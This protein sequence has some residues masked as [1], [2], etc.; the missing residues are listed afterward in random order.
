MIKNYIKIA[1]RNLLRNKVQTFINVAG[2]SLGMAV[3]MLIGFW[4][5]DELSFN[6]YFRNYDRIVQ[7]MQHQ[8][9]NGDVGTQAAI[10]MPLAPK[11]LQDYKADFKYMVMSSWTDEH[12]ITSGDKKLTQLGNYMQ[13]DAP[14][15][16]SLKM[17][18]GSRSGLTDQSSILLSATLAKSLFGDADP[19]NKAVRIDNRFNVKVTGVYEDMPLNTTFNDVAFISTWDLY[20]TTEPYLKKMQSNWDN[21]SWQLFAQINPGVDVSD[22]SSKIRNVKLTVYKTQGNKMALSF[23]PILFLQPMSKWHLYAEFKNGV[24]T[25]GAI[26]F[27]WMFGIIGVFVLVLACI[28]F[29]NLSTARSE[30]RAKEVG[31]RK[32]LGSDR[33]Q[34]ISQFYIESVLIAVF[35]F[36]ISLLL[37]QLAMPW[38]NNVAGKQMQVLWA[39]PFFWLM[40]ICFSLLTGV[41]AGS[42]PALYLSSF[43]P[44]KVLKGT[45]KAGRFAALPRKVLVVLQFAV[46]VML[47]IGTIVVF[48]QVEYTKDRPVGY[49]RFGLIQV[50]MKNDDIHK[51]F[52]ALRND[53]IQSGAVAEIAESGSPVTDIYSYTSDI[54]WQ[55]KDPA[56]QTNFATIPVTP[57]FG[58]T[59]GWNIIKG[60]DY[61]RKYLTD[62]SAV[63]L[64]EAAVKFM[65]FK[66]P[67]GQ[68]L[69]QGNSTYKVIGVIKDMVMTSPY[70][71]VNPT[72]FFQLSYTGSVVNIRINPK[73]GIHNAMARIITIFKQYDPDSPFNYNFSDSEYAMKF[74]DEERVGTLAGFFTVL[75][76]FISCLGLFGMAL[77][78]AEQRTKEIGVR[79]VLGASVLNLWGLMSKDFVALVSISILIATPIAYYFMQG[80]VK[81]YK[82]HEEL[83]WWIFVATAAGAIIITLLTVSYQSIKAALTNPVK[84]LRSE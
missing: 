43:M 33:K 58:K 79:K 47:I 49:S 30:K 36:L 82:Y 18:K 1:W 59:V 64:N 35:S 63:I 6:K 51:H 8:T 4:I 45:F 17:I 68:M 40:G 80:W 84:S 65:G 83:S 72:I 71:P 16:L 77:F 14:N 7:V 66:D 27:V 11:L 39:N 62:S 10:P 67:V 46:S 5:Y 38:F 19:M 60:R 3:V 32:T 44:V 70:D 20:L 81:N 61:S 52:A 24:N 42:Y 74:A 2:L 78:M 22:E 21:N 12:I 56:L 29:M 73:A 37:V 50:R 69:K 25:G 23:N 57:E 55:G 26:E 76:I 54:T 28:N 48:R 34:L 13:A 15:M 53:L 75:A 31:I 41:I 9:L